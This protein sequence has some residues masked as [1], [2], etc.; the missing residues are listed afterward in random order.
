M[1][2]AL[3]VDVDEYVWPQS[4][5][6]TTLV[7]L[8]TDFDAPNAGSIDF[9]SAFLLQKLDNITV[10]GNLSAIFPVN[11][12]S[13]QALKPETIY[14]QTVHLTWQYFSGFSAKQVDPNIALI[15]H[16]RE[17]KNIVLSSDK[18]LNRF[19]TVLQAILSQYNNNN[20]TV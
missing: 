18:S 12:R 11:D 8:L 10:M 15:Y 7:Q 4:E 14:R 3:T 17:A 1:R 13:K 16:V 20:K 9:R 19:R 6:V 2:F 5:N